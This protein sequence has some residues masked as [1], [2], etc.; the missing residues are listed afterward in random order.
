MPKIRWMLLSFIKEYTNKETT[1]IIEITL[2]TSFIFKKVSNFF[3]FNSKTIQMPRLFMAVFI[4]YISSTK[5]SYLQKN[6]S[7]HAD[8]GI[9]RRTSICISFAE[10]CINPLP[11]LIWCENRVIWVD[12]QMPISLDFCV[13]T[14]VLW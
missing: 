3:T 10:L 9:S 4:F 7:G 8:N 14:A 11:C 12:K 5:L 6:K 13:E 1:C 2:L